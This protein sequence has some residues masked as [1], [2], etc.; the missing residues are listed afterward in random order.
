MDSLNTREE[1]TNSTSQHI[2]DSNKICLQFP[3]NLITNLKAFLDKVGFL[4]V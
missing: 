2:V 1:D 3:Y 4:K